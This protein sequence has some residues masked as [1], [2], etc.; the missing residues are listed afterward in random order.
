MSAQITPDLPHRP[1]AAF[2]AYAGL[3]RAAAGER[4]CA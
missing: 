1:Q 4:G 2:P 3:G